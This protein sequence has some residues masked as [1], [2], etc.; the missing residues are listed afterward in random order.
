MV[1]R[2]SCMS[3]K[4]MHVW[5]RC[6][7]SSRHSPTVSLME[8]H[9]TFPRCFR[10]ATRR[11]GC[12]SPSSVLHVW[13][14]RRSSTALGRDLAPLLSTDFGKVTT[15]SEESEHHGSW[16]RNPSRST[17]AQQRPAGASP[18]EESGVSQRSVGRSLQRLWVSGTTCSKLSLEQV[19][20]ASTIVGAPRGS[21]RM[22]QTMEGCPLH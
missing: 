6:R 11:T 15:D 10:T 20:P 22:M 9:Q 14:R 21:P 12:M 1:W 4:L 7:D 17:G 3:S 8:V 19:N 13:C 16:M 2:G 5:E 18:G